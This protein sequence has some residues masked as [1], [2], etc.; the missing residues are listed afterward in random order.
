[1][2]TG[3]KGL[4]VGDIRK[5]IKKGRSERIIVSLIKRVKTPYKEFDFEEIDILIDD[6]ELSDNIVAT[7]IDV[8]TQLL[9]DQQKRKEQEYYLAEQ[10]KI[11]QETKNQ[12]V[13]E[14]VIERQMVNQNQNSGG[15]ELINAV[16]KEV[17]KELGKQLLDS[18]F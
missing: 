1:M 14:R 15:N 16:G 8:T 6:M 2:L 10:K 9:K 13:K 12:I 7:M 4:K 11:A 18:L 5:L 17:G 3:P